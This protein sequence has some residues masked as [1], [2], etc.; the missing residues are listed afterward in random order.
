MTSQLPREE[1]QASVYDLVSDVIEGAVLRRM[2][3]ET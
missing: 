1:L 3:D 2:T